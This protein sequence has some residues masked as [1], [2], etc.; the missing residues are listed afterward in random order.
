MTVKVSVIIPV[1]N[2]EAFLEK[3]LDSVL[4]QS[5]RELE[6]ICVDDGSRD[7]SP[8]ILE[9]FAAQDERVVL[10]KQQNCGAGAARNNGLSH[11]LG[12]YIFFMDSD[13]IMLPNTL[14]KLWRQAH[15]QRLDVLRC[16]A[17]DY[18][19]VSGKTTRS[20]HN[21]L[22]RVPPFLYGIPTSYRPVYWL[23]PKINVAPWGGIVRKSFL[24]DNNIEFNRL[25][26][27]NDRSF[28]WETILKAK[29]IGFS[30]VTAILYRMNLTDSLIGTRIRNFECHFQSYEIVE[31]LCRDLPNRYRRN[32]LNGELMDIINW[33]EVGKK[34][35][36]A[37]T[38]SSEM[39]HFL[40]QHCIVQT[41]FRLIHGRT[42]RRINEQ[43]GT[44]H[45][46]CQS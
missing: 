34:T 41:K 22:K 8:E 1:Y 17:L 11:A 45:S 16:R 12:E 2:A 30:R 19:N 15:R 36:L 6:V 33:F 7:K 35:D 5:L 24:I 26:C 38:I 42:K 25:K 44:T 29:R 13:D 20:L 39:E 3:C 28:Y 4:G 10:I 21:Y 40:Q 9:T 32:I 18:D 46:K 37:D 27:V 43:K 23:F 14:E 31:R